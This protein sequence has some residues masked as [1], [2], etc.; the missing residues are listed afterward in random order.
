MQS[1]TVAVKTHLQKG[2][3][4]Q[5]SA[6]TVIMLGGKAEKVKIMQSRCGKW[7]IFLRLC[8]QAMGNDDQY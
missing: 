6:E 8:V 3:S 1:I 7:V 2:F 4:A 5:Q